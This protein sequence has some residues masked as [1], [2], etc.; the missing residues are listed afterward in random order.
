MNV[1]ENKTYLKSYQVRFRKRGEGKADYC[2]WK[3]VGI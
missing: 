3:Q 2:A 1:V